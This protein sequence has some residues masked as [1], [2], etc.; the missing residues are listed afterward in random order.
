MQKLARL[1]PVIDRVVAEMPRWRCFCCQDTGFVVR[2][3]L[4]LDGYCDGSGSEFYAPTDYPLLCKACDGQYQHSHLAVDDRLTPQQCRDIHS[5]RHDD[6]LATVQEKAGMENP[7]VRVPTAIANPPAMLREERPNSSL[8]GMGAILGRN[9]APKP[10][11]ERSILEHKGF[12][13]GDVVVITLEQFDKASQTNM[14]NSGE[15]PY[16]GKIATIKRWEKNTAMGIT[17][18]EPVLDVE[19]EEWTAITAWLKPLE[20][21]A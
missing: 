13:V 17:T 9:P 4:V 3:E 2:Q 21:A 1:K 5:A 7:S 12:C 19:G 16:E 18:I 14:R 15:C 20:V 6:W 11:P 10:T 8:V